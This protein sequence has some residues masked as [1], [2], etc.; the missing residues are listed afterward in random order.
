MKVLTAV[1]SFKGSIDSSEINRIIAKE[2]ENRGLE[3]IQKPLA[4]GGEGTIDALID[5]EIAERI[6]C[7]VTGGLGEK[8]TSYYAMMH[9]GTA[10]IEI[11]QI[12]GLPMIPPNK[13]NPLYTTTYGVGEAIIH[14]IE[15]GAVNIVI[16]LGG[17]ATNDVGIGM[18]QALGVTITTPSHQSVLS[19]AAALEAI[20]H[21]DF[22]TCITSNKDVSLTVITDVQNPL[23][24]PDGAT[25]IFGPQKGMT[26]DDLMQIEK[27]IQRLCT[28]S[29]ILQKYQDTPGAGAAGG[30]G[31]ACLALGA[32]IFDGA[33]W[34]MEKLQIKETIPQV[35]V[36]I[37]G[38]G[39]LDSQTLSG[40]AP[41][42]IARHAQHLNKS[43][44]AIAG[45]ID[46][47]LLPDFYESGIK[48]CL[49]VIPGIQTL[50]QAMSLSQVQKNISYI[51]QQ[52]AS[53]LTWSKE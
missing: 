50:E 15:H 44:I 7:T 23:W 45:S 11:A 36:V 9:D 22:S 29:P 42:S 47:S 2:L 10:V 5:A 31:A 27:Q 14:A 49:S 6:E 3:V 38:E 40:K 33:D 16:T 20:T 32:Q 30:L 24:G 12:C 4:D 1:D 18:L 41:V 25:Y 35:D 52:I 37:T 48:S 51:S 28:I 21:I 13:R 43:V 19:G 53:F 17:S 39:R 26:P 34:F 46:T 8:I